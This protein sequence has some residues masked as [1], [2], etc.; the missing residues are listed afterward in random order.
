MIPDLPVGTYKPLGNTSLTGASMAFLSSNARNEVYKL[1]DRITYIELN[2]NQDFVNNFS[3]ARFIPHT[4]RPLFP[5]V[6][7]GNLTAPGLALYLKFVNHFLQ[8]LSKLTQ[9][10][11]TKIHLRTVV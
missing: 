1:R 5:S 11:G 3:V 8:F 7:N 2:V 4:D 6:K 9:S 10:L